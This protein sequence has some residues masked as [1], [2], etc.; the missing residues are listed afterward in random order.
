[1]TESRIRDFIHLTRLHKPVGTILL[2]WPALW[3]LW[4]AAGGIPDLDVLVIFIAGGFVMRAAGC[5]INDFADRHFDAHVERTNYRPIATGRIRPAEAL[6][7]FVALSLL[8]FVLV[9]LTNRLTL[10]LACIGV[11]IIAAY[12]FAKRHTH[13]PQLVLG[14]AWAWSIPMAF[15]AQAGTIPAGVAVLAFGVICWTIVFD[16]FYAMVDREDDLKIGIK[17]TAILFG[18]RD[19]IAIAV[20]QVMTVAAL[21]AT[22]LIF[23]LGTP[24]FAGVA[25][26][27]ALFGHQLRVARHRD[28]SGCFRAFMAN[29]WIGLVVFIAIAADYAISGPGPALS[30]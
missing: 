12:P 18:E 30:Q 9:L 27:A 21:A 14:V 23:A 7:L 17:S 11:V 20:F 29:R 13:L 16:T 2:L 26:V 19:L 24:F 3:S 5:V 1:M 15:A 22:G 25:V 28:R 10:Y 4:L 8:G 6:A